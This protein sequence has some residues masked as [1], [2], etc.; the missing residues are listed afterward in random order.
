MF[1]GL[2]AL[3]LSWV[4]VMIG[5]YGIGYVELKNALQTLARVGS[6]QHRYVD[7]HQKL[8]EACLRF[9]KNSGRIFS[10]AV[11][12]RVRIAFVEL[13]IISPRV[14]I[15]SYGEAKALE[16]QIQYR[17]K[18]IFKWVPQLEGWLTS[19]AYRYWLGTLQA[20]LGVN[21]SSTPSSSNKNSADDLF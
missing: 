7:I 18:G 9:A 21:E 14:R 13:G 17:H 1:F 11:I 16:M 15:L 5:D 2:D 8:L 3:T 6:R 20:C 4:L 12:A 10:T 19:P